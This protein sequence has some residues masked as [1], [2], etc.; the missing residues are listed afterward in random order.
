MLFCFLITTISFTQ[1]KQILYNFTTIPQSL[2]TNPGADVNYKWYSGVPFLSGISLNM[3]ST[4][5][6]AYDLFAKDGVGFNTKIRNLLSS[7]TARDWLAINEQLELFNGGFRIGTEEKRAYLSFGL[8]Q[9]LDFFGY[10]PHDLVVLAI[11]G[12]KEYLGKS[13]NLGDVSAKAE[14]LSVFHVGYHKKIQDNLI[15]GFRAKIYSS[16]FN[17][18]SINNSGYIYTAPS[19]DAFYTQTIYSDLQLNTSGVGA[20]TSGNYNGNAASDIKNGIL[21]GGNLGLGVDLGIT[22]YPKPNLQITA[23]LLDLGFVNHTKNVESYTYKGV[24]NYKGLV[25]NFN[26]ENAA[27]ANYKEFEKAIVLDTLHSKYTTW[28]PSKFNTSIQYS[29][30]EYKED[31]ACNCAGGNN[32]VFYKSGI[33][34]QLFIMTTP[35]SPLFALTT[36]YKRNFSKALQMKATYTVDSY[37]FTNVGLG[38]STQLGVV[39]FYALADNLFAYT[40]VSKAKSLSFQLGLNIVFKE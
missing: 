39:N 24:Y 13:F 27:E 18:S 26:N 16:I 8:Y 19:T 5:F 11:N 20:F 31:E 35:K 38:F 37:S 25:P 15:L 34:A 29:F 32:G 17:A 30:E 40:D 33:G 14:V 3:G 10:I 28:R 22:Y 7:T 6:S 12:N 1:N 21:L 2:M 9:E 36:F 4:G 23:S